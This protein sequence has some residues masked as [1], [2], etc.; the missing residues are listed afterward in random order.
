MENIYECAKDMGLNLQILETLM[1]IEH[2]M[3]KFVEL[4]E[5]SK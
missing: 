2:V 5:L 1:F 4:D 3:D